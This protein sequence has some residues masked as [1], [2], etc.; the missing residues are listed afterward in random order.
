[1]NPWAGGLWTENLTP[2]VGELSVDE[3]RARWD[4]DGKGDSNLRRA[5]RAIPC[6]APFGPFISHATYTLIEFTHAN[7]RRRRFEH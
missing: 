7:L 2:A 1:M 3:P 4:A 6:I 5:L